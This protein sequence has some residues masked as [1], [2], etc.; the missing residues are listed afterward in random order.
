MTKPQFREKMRKL[1]KDTYL[2]S[3][4]YINKFID[5]GQLPLDDYEDDFALPKAC[6]AALCK[7]MAFQW[8]PSDKE[9]KEI[10]KIMELY[11]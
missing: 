11:T 10:S 7:E 2:S 4:Q 8:S 3:G 9:L 5:S 1:I 6:M